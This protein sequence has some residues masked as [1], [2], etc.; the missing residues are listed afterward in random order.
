MDELITL[1]HQEDAQLETG[2]MA[3]R[4]TPREV[5]SPLS[6]LALRECLCSVREG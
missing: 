5:W 3:A 2:A 1:I 6:S 4:E